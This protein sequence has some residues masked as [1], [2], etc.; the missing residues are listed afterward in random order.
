MSKI[1]E[2]ETLTEYTML[3]LAISAYHLE[4]SGSNV[5]CH[6]LC[7]VASATESVFLLCSVFVY[8]FS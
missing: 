6:A 3:D 1:L 8:D 2:K 5:G 7:M 4:D